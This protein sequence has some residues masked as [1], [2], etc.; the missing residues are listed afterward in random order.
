MEIQ[1]DN[2]NETK[3]VGQAQ[4]AHKIRD[5][6]QKQRTSSKLMNIDYTEGW[7][8]HYKGEFMRIKSRWSCFVRHIKEILCNRNI[9]MSRDG[10]EEFR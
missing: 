10:E 3:K 8:K 6:P 4:R 7:A 9:P 5:K 1:P 2:L